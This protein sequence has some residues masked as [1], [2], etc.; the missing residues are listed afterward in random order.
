MGPE[1]HAGASYG[2][3]RKMKFPGSWTLANQRRGGRFG[4]RVS[5]F[6]TF[7]KIWNLQIAA[8]SGS[9][10]CGFPKATLEYRTEGGER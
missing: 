10:M 1:G 8:R 7:P 4:A 2:G 6:P 9:A 3:T 5:R